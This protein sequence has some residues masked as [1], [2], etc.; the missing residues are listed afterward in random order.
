MSNLCLRSSVFVSLTRLQILSAPFSFHAADCRRRLQIK[1]GRLVFLKV[2]AV[3]E[4]EDL[5]MV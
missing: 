5:R 4:L 3:Q 1:R 2:S